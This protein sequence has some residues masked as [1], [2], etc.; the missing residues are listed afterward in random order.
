MPLFV[1]SGSGTLDLAAQSFTGFTGIEFQTNGPLTVLL[2]NLQFGPLQLLTDAVFSA[3]PAFASIVEIS[4]DPGLTF[5]GSSFTTTSFGADDLFRFNDATGNESLTGTQARDIFHIGAGGSDF[6]DGNLG[7]NTLVMDYSDLTNGVFSTGSGFTNF[8]NRGVNFANIQTFN[9]TTGSGNDNLRT[10][11]GDDTV[12]ARAGN[13]TIDTAKGVA[14][15]DGGSG[16]DG[17]LADF[18]DDPTAKSINLNRTDRSGPQDAGGGSTYRSIEWMAIRGGAGN[19]SFISQ[20]GNPNDG[21]ADSLYGG[22]GNDRMTVGGGSDSVDGGSGVDLLIIDYSYDNGNFNMAGANNIITDFS[23]TS[24]SFSNIERFV[25][26]LGSGNDN[27]LLGDGSDQMFGGAGND[28]LNSGRGDGTIDGGTGTDLW[29]ADFSQTTSAKTV[30]INLAGVQSTADGSTY[31]NLERLGLTGGAGSDVFVTRVGDTG[32]GFNDTLNGG[33]GDD[34]L[35]VGGGSDL[36][37]GGD[38]D[39]LLVV[40]YAT[41]NL[42]IQMAGANIF[43]DLSNTSVTF[44]NIERFSLTLGS[45]NDNVL[46]GAGAD[47]LNGGAG[48]DTLNSGLGGGA[49]DGGDGTDLWAADF[50][51]N[52]T[53]ALIDINLA[54]VNT[55]G[56]GF[57]YQKIESLRLT[58]GGGNDTFTSRVG[59][60]ND[61]L[62]D[63]LNGGFGND[64]LTVG[65]GADVVDGGNGNDLLIVDYSTDTF[66]LQMA[67]ANDRF[68]DFSN[69]SVV[70]SNIERFSL[71][72]GSGNDNVLTGAGSD[73][74][75]GGLGNDTLNSGLGG[76]AVDGGDGNDLWAADFS[77]NATAALINLNLTDVNTTGNGFTYQKIESLR[78]TGG[79]GNDTFTSRVGSP[80]D[81]LN[82]SLNGGSGNDTLT[83]GGGNDTVDGGDGDLLIVDYSTETFGIQM[84]GANVQFTDFS[85]TAV[86]FSNIERFNLSLGSGN[87]NVFAGQGN[88]T[89][90]GGGGTDNLNGGGGV[91]LLDLQDA[92]ET[93]VL[94]LGKTGNGVVTAV[95]IGTDIFQNMENVAGGSAADRLTGN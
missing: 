69:T 34:T 79:G 62:N 3:S 8:S 4:V 2:S 67:G 75:N 5:V 36:V 77:D 25:V 55:S 64:T 51:D 24:V 28:V 66:A 14:I 40:A 45:G 29:I 16:N 21:L 44:S 76:G 30:N 85:N 41:E 32:D 54:G 93:V 65:G 84:G 1:V 80:N 27:I 72:L 37:D 63:T 95:G 49:V 7:F 6:I 58:G 70:F 33:L 92:T 61:G 68:T 39:D 57:T 11:D 20:V 74:L 53:A 81:G 19:D 86:T 59:N 52:A 12:S 73:T 94:K 88:D 48:N 18:S 47:T 38:G 9:L 31:S 46:T 35:T 10:L 87:D 50:S 23:N 15:V 91:D 17:W 13:D 42:A 71:T 22:G 78:V 82:D 60:A 89:L 56:N 90:R 26:R 43:T 83:V